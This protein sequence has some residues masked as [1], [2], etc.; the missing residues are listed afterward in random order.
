MVRGRI[1]ANDSMKNFYFIPFWRIKDCDKT[2]KDRIIL[3][4]NHKIYE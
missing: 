1:A 4:K 3:T 2:L